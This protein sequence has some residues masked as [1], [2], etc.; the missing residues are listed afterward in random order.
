VT[1][2]AP[3]Q[4]RAW[5][6]WA[7]ALTR[8]G[9]D[10]EA[11][12]RLVAEAALV[13]WGKLASPGDQWPLR[14]TVHADLARARGLTEW[15]TAPE[16]DLQASTIR[17]PCERLVYQHLGPIWRHAPFRLWAADIDRL[18]EPVHVNNRGSR[19]PGDAALIEGGLRAINEGRAANAS[20]AAKLVAD[21]AE[22]AS[23]DAKTDRLR[24]AI[25]GRLNPNFPQVPPKNT[26]HHD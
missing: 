17:C 6:T 18:R 9:G 2:A 20:Q 22:G 8:F 13:P 3:L 25:Q 5:I 19:Y 16:L 7:E 15:R 12:R 1:A 21:R 10:D 14:M 23:F 11:L 4:A 26:K 24:R